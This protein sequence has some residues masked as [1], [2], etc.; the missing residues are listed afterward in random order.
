MKDLLSHIQMVPMSQLA[1]KVYRRLAKEGGAWFEALKD[2]RVCTY[3]RAEYLDEQ[4]PIVRIPGGDAMYAHALSIKALADNHM[5]SLFTILD[6]GWVNMS[7]KRHD[8]HVRL[9]ESV[10]SSN[11]PESARILDVLLHSPYGL[12]RGANYY[13]ISRLIGNWIVN[14]DIVGMHSSIIVKFNMVWFRAQILKFRGNWDDSRMP[15]ISP[16]P[17]C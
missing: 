2:K 4:S 17:Q 12:K 15:Q 9:K 1:S 13:I 16:L 10:T 8:H 5:Q 14:P 3:A 6:S 7:V 11:Y